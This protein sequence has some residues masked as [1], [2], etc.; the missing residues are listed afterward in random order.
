MIRAGGRGQSFNRS[1]VKF[2]TLS[3]EWQ[4]DRVCIWDY[5]GSESKPWKSVAVWKDAYGTVSHLSWGHPQI[6][7]FLAMS[8][9]DR[10]IIICKEMSSKSN[11]IYL[12]LQS[13]KNVFTIVLPHFPATDIQ[14]S[15]IEMGL[16]LAVSTTDG[17]IWLYSAPSDNLYNW[18]MVQSV[19][20]PFKCTKLIWNPS[21]K[22]E[23]LPKNRSIIKVHQE[24]KK[25][26]LPR[27]YIRNALRIGRPTRTAYDPNEL[28]KMPFVP[29]DN[30][31]YILIPQH[32]MLAAISDEPSKNGKG[33]ISFVQYF[34][35]AKQWYPL[36][37]KFD[38]KEPVYDLSFIP[39]LNRCY[40]MFLVAS[41]QI[42]L[43]TLFQ[44]LNK[45]GVV[46]YQLNLINTFANEKEGIFKVSWDLIGSSVFSA[47]TDKSIRLWRENEKHKFI[48][49]AVVTPS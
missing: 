29:T 10:R 35:A 4:V 38:G 32:Q 46:R 17:K 2:K 23:K 43:Y 20:I 9:C 41:G 45:N 27:D 3:N 39:R 1:K 21:Y 28:P 25:R 14:F 26:P 15:P 7:Q 34:P 33:L 19:Y 49:T 37:V 12:E 13:W 44:I 30:D 8:C 48:N 6:G 24:Q 16:I 5:D 22:R 18:E 42:H 36:S 11:S 47:G 31:Q 40:D